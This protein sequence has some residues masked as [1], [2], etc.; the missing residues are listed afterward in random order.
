MVDGAHRALRDTWDA[1]A[2]EYARLVP[3]LRTETAEDR[4]V[5]DA[6]V[7]LVD[8]GVVADVGCGTGRVTSHLQDAGL[9]MLGL[10]LS[11]AMLS[12]ASA[13]HPHLAL[14]VGDAVALPIRSGSLG[15]L[16]AWYSIIN[17]TPAELPGVLA[18]CARVLRPGAPLVLAFQCAAGERVDRTSAYGVSVPMTYFRHDADLVAE[19]LGSAGLALHT[20][21]R[22]EP[23]LPHESTPQALL[24]ARRR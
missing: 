24:I 18:E 12:V 5:L 17:L 10:D 11:P 22:R 1:V 15:G 20:D 7:D 8:G 3:D 14:T 23:S 21:V 4:A 9:S 16:V 19:A 13:A 2:S 6:F